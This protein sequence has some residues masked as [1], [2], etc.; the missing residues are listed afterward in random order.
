M[1]IPEFAAEASLYRTSKN[2]VLT[3]GMAGLASTRLGLAEVVPSIGK[4]PVGCGPCVEDSD[5]STG[6]SRTCQ[7]ADCS[8][9]TFQCTGCSHT[10]TCGPCTGTKTCCTGPFCEGVACTC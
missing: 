7:R 3:T 6:C 10:T 5:F 4:C 8:T 1:R 2:Y 9:T